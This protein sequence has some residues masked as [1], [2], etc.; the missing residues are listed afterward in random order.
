MP[1]YVTG[2]HTTVSSSNDKILDMSTFVDYIRGDDMDTALIRR[3]G[4]NG[5]DGNTAHATKTE[6]TQTA[7]RSRGETV[8]QLVGDVTWT[9][10][11][12]RMYQVGELIRCE[13][14]IV[15]VT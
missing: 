5:K 6:W 12:A 13:A 4:I 2:A 7:L 14:E 11:D 3:W 8:T 15:R 9:V 10:A 1:P